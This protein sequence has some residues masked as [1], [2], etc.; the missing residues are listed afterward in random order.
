MNSPSW[1]PT[2]GGQNCIKTFKKPL[3]SIHPVK[4]LTQENSF[5]HNSNSTNFV[6]KFFSITF[7]HGRYIVK[8]IW[9]SPL[10]PYIKIDKKNK[11]EFFF[12]FWDFFGAINEKWFFLTY[13]IWWTTLKTTIFLVVKKSNKRKRWETLM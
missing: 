2:S 7:Y 5:I 13:F 6:P 11:R 1:V 8:G 9:N 12:H 3:A 4:G 10:V